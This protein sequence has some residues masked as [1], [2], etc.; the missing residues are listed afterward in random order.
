MMPHIGGAQN[1]PVSIGR[2]RDRV[3]LCQWS[4]SR[5]PHP[6]SSI[7]GTGTRDQAAGANGTRRPRDAGCGMRPSDRHADGADIVYG[8]VN[9]AGL[10]LLLTLFQEREPVELEIES[11]WFPLDLAYIHPMA[12]PREPM[13]GVRLQFPFKSGEDPKIE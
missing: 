6:A 7:R 4:A 3:H 1:I 8:S 5:I 11:V 10:L 9:A 12:D 13:S 2:I